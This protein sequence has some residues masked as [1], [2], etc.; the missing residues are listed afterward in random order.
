[1]NETEYRVYE[2]RLMAQ[3]IKEIENQSLADK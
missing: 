1:M 3:R 2:R